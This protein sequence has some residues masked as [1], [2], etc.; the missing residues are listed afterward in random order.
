LRFST[1]FFGFHMQSEDNL[2]HLEPL[3]QHLNGRSTGPKFDRKNLA[4]MLA[5]LQQFMED[6][7][8]VNVRPRSVLACQPR[9]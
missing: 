7:L 1:P 9:A 4:L 8:G 6:A 3:V 5:G 2:K